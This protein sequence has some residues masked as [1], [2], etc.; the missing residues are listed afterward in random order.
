MAEQASAERYALAQ[1]AAALAG[2]SLNNDFAGGVIED[3]DSNVIVGEAGFELLGNFGEHLVGVERSDGVAG[4]IVEQREM[5]S[6]G[7]FLVEQSGV[8]NGDTGLAGKDAEKFEMSFV[9]GTLVLREDRHGTDGM[10]V[11]HE[12]HTHK[13]ATAQEGLD[14]ELADLV[15][16]VLTDQDGLAGANDVLGDVIA[17][18]TCALGHVFA[19]DDFDVEDHFVADGI[20]RAN[21]EILDIEEAAQ[22]FPNFTEQIFLV[23]RGA[24]SAADFIE[25]VEFFGTARSLLDEVAV[26]N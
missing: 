22:L 16:I 6:F 10:V 5:P 1:D 24:Q 19:V 25:D 14:A 15:G 12:R 17:R 7:A 8:F 18:G 3:A 13:A 21:I 4:D 9:E 20:E 23:E 11:S 2:F 26:F